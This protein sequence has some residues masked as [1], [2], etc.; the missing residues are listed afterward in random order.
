[1]ARIPYFIGL[2]TIVAATFLVNGIAR[3]QPV[4]IRQPLNTLPLKMEEW[5]GQTEFLEPG[6][7]AGLA[8]DDYV[9]R[10]YLIPSA[11]GLWSYVAYY[12]A[13]RLGSARVH[14]P[15]ICLPGNGWIITRRDTIPI[16]LGSRTIVVNSNVVQKANQSQLVLYW[17]QIHGKAVAK[18]WHAVTFLAWTSLT[19]H[20]S[21]EAL[22]RINAPITGSLEETLSR[23]VAFVQTATPWLERML[24]Q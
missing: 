8:A 1:M 20:R 2:A 11:G 17:Y 16:S 5:S 22:V 3:S 7:L 4:S 15:S 23:E 10:R 21:D 19:Q 9:L 24:P 13:Q 6:I 18:E 12:G 14:S